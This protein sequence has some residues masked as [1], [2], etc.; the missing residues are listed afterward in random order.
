MQFIELQQLCTPEM[1]AKKGRQPFY[2]NK[3]PFFRPQTLSHVR[4]ESSP[5]YS[6]LKFFSFF[7]RWRRF[8]SEVHVELLM[9]V[10]IV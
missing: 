8:S 3:S 4:V 1:G 9:N 5:L 7:H 10:M 6:S 2:D